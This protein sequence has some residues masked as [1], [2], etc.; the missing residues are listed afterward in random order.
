MSVE[1]A[2][3]FVAKMK[4]DEDFSKQVKECNTS[5]ERIAFV[6][7]AGFDFT[8]E[9]MKEV[10]GD[11]SDDELD[12]VAGAGCFCTTVISEGFIM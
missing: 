9:E 3:A 5:D 8:A 6:N 4:T 10:S 12:S 7:Q 1:S 2:K 11:L